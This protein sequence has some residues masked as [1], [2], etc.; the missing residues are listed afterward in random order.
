MGDPVVTNIILGGAKVL[1]APVGEAPP[2]PNSVDY[3]ADWGGEWARVGFTKAP[4]VAAYDFEESDVEVEEEL[5]PIDRMRT[6]ENLMLETTLA[7]LIAEYLALALSQD[8]DT[9]V[10]ETPSGAGQVGVEEFS[11]GGNPILEKWTFGFEGRYVDSSGSEFPVRLFIHKAT[12]TINGNLEFSQK[13]GDYPGVAI[14]V[15]AL[16]DPSQSAGEKLFK[17]ER[18]TAAESS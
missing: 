5:S 3:D 7:E 6:A 9:K 13:S 18:V 14:Q 4:L 11:F 10:T 17:F 1:Y 16:A 12:V 2:D 15:K 8:P